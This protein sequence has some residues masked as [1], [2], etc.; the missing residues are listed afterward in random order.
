[1]VAQVTSTTNIGQI[2]DHSSNDSD[3]A[4]FLKENGAID[5]VKPLTA[6]YLCSHKL[7]LQSKNYL[8]CHSRNVVRMKLQMP[9]SKTILQN[10]FHLK[11]F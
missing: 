5:E 11:A 4:E 6:K 8:I 3:K 7:V 2:K 9:Q 1:M 10:P